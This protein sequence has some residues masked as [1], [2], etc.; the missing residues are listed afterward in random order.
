MFEKVYKVNGEEVTINEIEGMI[1]VDND[2][3]A[4]MYNELLDECG[5][6]N[7]G[8]LT[9]EASRVLQSV[10]P[11]AYRCGYNDYC[12]SILSDVEYELSYMENGDTN[13]F[14][15]IEIEC[16]VNVPK[17]PEIAK[18]RD[19]DELCNK[20]YNGEC[21]KCIINKYLESCN[22][23]Y[24]CDEVFAMLKEVL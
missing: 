11:I 22:N 18:Y 13:E 20:G 21:D 17:E 2:V 15:G 10:D 23:E 7:I 5:D 19:L 12:D 24:D 3:I 14:Y 8:G 1:E 16:A 9:Y 6:V 4:Q